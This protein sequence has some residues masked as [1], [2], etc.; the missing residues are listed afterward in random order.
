MLSGENEIGEL[1]PEETRDGADKKSF[2]WGKIKNISAGLWL[3]LL[4]I[5]AIVMVVTVPLISG[6]SLAG[7]LAKPSANG[8]SSTDRVHNL[9]PVTTTPAP[10]ITPVIIS[11]TRSPQVQA[12]T[13][14][15]YVTIEAV[16]VTSP[17]RVQDLSSSLPVSHLDNLFTIYSLTGQRVQQI[18]PYVSFSLVNPPLVIDYTVTPLNVTEV[19]ELDYK[20]V[21]KVYH[22]K[23]II[24]RPYEQA[25]F[26]VVVRDRET[27]KVVLE[28]GYG[29]TYSLD[30][31]RRLVLYTGGNYR[32][33]FTGAYVSVDLA[34]KVNKEG[35]IR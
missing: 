10:V 31:S 3:L 8:S 12:T 35:N 7:A 22:E 6:T 11:S 24:N 2:P 28:D 14:K 4:I 20:I 29:K 21:S 13:P 25:W 34:M 15:S 19:K 23:L 30:P 32:F 33:E 27:G 18:L 16:P 5:A 9:S 17:P 26:L 1:Q